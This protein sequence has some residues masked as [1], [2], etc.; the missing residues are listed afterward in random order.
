MESRKSPSS[1]TNS[2]QVASKGKSLV[3]SELE[4][5]GAG[6]VTPDKGRKSCL[7]ASS[8]DRSRTVQIRVK[9]KTNENWQT[10]IDEAQVRDTPPHPNDETKF[11]IFVDLTT[12]RYWIAPDSWVRKNIR[13]AHHEYLNQ[14]GGRRPRNDASHHHSI[15][16]KRLEQ[17]QDRWDILRIFGNVPVTASEIQK[18]LAR[19]SDK[20]DVRKPPDER[21]RRQ[22]RIGWHDTTE[23]GKDYTADTLARLTW[24]NLGYRLGQHFGPQS[25]AE[26]DRAYEVAAREYAQSN[27]ESR[28][29][30]PDEIDE[31]TPLRE[32]A[33]YQVTVNAYERDPRARRQCVAHYGTSCVICGFSFGAVYGEIAK[34]FIHVHHVRPLAEVGAEYSVDPVADLRP[35]CPNCHAV[36]HLHKP[37]LSIQ[38]VAAL[39]RPRECA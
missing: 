38:E 36:I 27:K 29:L 22:F 20:P 11:W 1:R 28:H 23:R 33:Q 31:V 19:L 26:I 5:R 7:L 13:E 24:H 25:P 15:D 2:H 35:V 4:K 37:A 21:R 3:A 12:P 18:L 8:A 39:L 16:E 32:G 6:C 10:T 14:H 30:F 17:W 34:D 9:A